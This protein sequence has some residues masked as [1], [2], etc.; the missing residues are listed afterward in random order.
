[1][2]PAP[3]ENKDVGFI[4]FKLSDNTYSLGLVGGNG[5]VRMLGLSALSY[6]CG[7]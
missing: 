4:I 2:F 6:N 3:D 7:G 5:S 1:M